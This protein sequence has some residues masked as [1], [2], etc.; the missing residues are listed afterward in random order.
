MVA[1]MAT[2]RTRNLEVGTLK[3]HFVAMYVVY[4]TDLH[5]LVS[6]SSNLRYFVEAV[7]VAEARHLQILMEGAYFVNLEAIVDFESIECLSHGP[8][9]FLEN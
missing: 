3:A 9:N 1:E 5:E 6:T 2:V 4:L 8:T 7:W